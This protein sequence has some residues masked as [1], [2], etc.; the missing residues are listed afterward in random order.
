MRMILLLIAVAAILVLGVW[1]WPA[2]AHGP[3]ASPERSAPSLPPAIPP[4][5][6]RVE[7]LNIPIARK[8]SSSTLAPVESAIVAEQVPIPPPSMPFGEALAALE[9]HAGAGDVQARIR[10]YHQARCCKDMDGVSAYVASA[11]SPHFPDS[12]RAHLQAL[13]SYL[14]ALDAICGKVPRLGNARLQRYQSWAREVGDPVALLEFASSLPMSFSYVEATSFDEQIQRLQARRDGALPALQRALESGNLDAVTLLA[15]LHATPNLHRELGSLVQQSW[16]TTAVYNLLY[17]R[18]GGQ[19]F[20]R[21]YE[22]FVTMMQ[23]RLTPAELAMAQQ[24]AEALY[25]R[26]FAGKPITEFAPGLV[27]GLLPA[28]EFLP[29]PALPGLARCPVRPIPGVSSPTNTTRR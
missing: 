20:R 22:G 10:L 3:A 23:R 11:R 13:E 6:A 7:A 2:P 9:S 14:L 24:Q 21:Q 1:R 8:V 27:P 15:S 16:P 5:T 19:A 29:S 12:Q 25:Q 28:P 18:A 26:H 4:D 17:L